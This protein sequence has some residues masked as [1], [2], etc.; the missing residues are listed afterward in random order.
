MLLLIR[1]LL[2]PVFW[3]PLGLYVESQPIILANMDMVGAGQTALLKGQ[4][5]KAQWAL[6]GALYL[7]SSNPGKGNPSLW[8]RGLSCFYSGHYQEG[9]RQ[10]EHDMSVNGND[11]EEV[12]WHFLCRCCICGYQKAH[13][14]GFLALS[15]DYTSTVVPMQQ[16]L[17]L[18][19]GTGS[20]QEVLTSATSSDGSMVTSYNDTN[21]LAY[22]HFYIG[23]YH[24]M[25]KEISVAK[26]HFKAAAE[27]K[28]PD[29]IG[30]LMQMHFDLFSCKFPS[31]VISEAFGM[32]RKSKVIHGG[33]QLSQGHLIGSRQDGNCKAEMVKTL[34]RVLDAGIRSFDCGDIYSGVEEIYGR[35]IKAHSLRGGKLDDIAI[36]TKL[37]PDLDA[38]KG[39]SV[40]R[41]Y[42]ES[43]TKRSLNRLGVEC[44]DLVQFHWWDIS[45]S[46]YVEACLILKDLVEEGKI[47]NI[48]ITNF[49]TET[50]K[51]FID[52][53]IKIVSTQVNND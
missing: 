4:F 19:K 48:G 5:E 42:I 50:T 49:D 38:I 30:R 37:V 31:I 47:K 52:A 16:V 17:E 29:F 45:V 21:A 46:G 15:G 12:V 2:F 6:D 18:Y 10:F 40:N 11:V 35:F 41:K 25:R 28:N 27:L 32:T 36:H 9:V 24:E 3:P 20:V 7:H 33:W 22:A 44:L 39:H 23:I 34:L 8:Q 53:G 14:D 1:S 51:M 43:V 26:K 13:S